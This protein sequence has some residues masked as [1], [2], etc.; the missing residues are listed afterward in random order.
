VQ[1]SDYIADAQYL[2]KDTSGLFVPTAQLTRWINQTREEIAEL[3]G[4]LNALVAG[5]SPFGA[6]AQAGQAL[7][8]GAIAGVQP[9]AFPYAG[10]VTNTSFQTIPGTESYPFSYANPYLQAQYAGFGRVLDIGSVAVTWG[11]L[12]RVCDWWPWDYMQAYG[13]IWAVANFT[14]PFAASVNGDGTNKRLWLFPPPSI[15]SDM[16]WDCYCL[17]QQLNEAGTVVEALPE[18]FQLAVKYGAARLAFKPTRP[19]Q[20][21]IMERDM[22]RQLGID[23]VASDRGKTSYF[24]S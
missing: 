14:Y 20:A 13:R 12:R 1:L 16:E 3:T 24:Y 18:P 11:N 5:Q 15:A 7:V 2:L 9:D 22:M 8:G 4:C 17:P 23:R 19:A 21:D 6:G 10:D